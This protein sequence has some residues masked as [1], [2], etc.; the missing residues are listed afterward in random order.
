[1]FV[2]P[3]DQVDESLGLT[4]WKSCSNSSK[5]PVIVVELSVEAAFYGIICQTNAGA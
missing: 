2:L 4:G 3:P 1:M 5:Y